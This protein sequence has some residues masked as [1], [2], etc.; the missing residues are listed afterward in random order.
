[1]VVYIACKAWKKKQKRAA[2][3][4]EDVPSRAKPMVSAKDSDVYEFP[5]NPQS[6]R[7]QADPLVTMQPNPAYSMHQ[8]DTKKDGLVYANINSA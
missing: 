5:D 4:E 2:N 3:S 7:Y 6:T 1:M 8:F